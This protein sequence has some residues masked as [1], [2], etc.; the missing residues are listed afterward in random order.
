MNNLEERL[1]RKEAIQRYVFLDHTDKKKDERQANL[2]LIDCHET[3]A[4]ILRVTV[5]YF[6][7]IAFVFCPNDQKLPSLSYLLV[8]DHHQHHAQKPWGR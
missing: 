1:F 4:A 8:S 6:V 3:K 2:W 7:F 5:L